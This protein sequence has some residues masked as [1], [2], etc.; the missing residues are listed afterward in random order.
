MN[1]LHTYPT[2]K[3]EMARQIFR[4]L[5]ALQLRL[6]IVQKLEILDQAEVDKCV[7]VIDRLMETLLANYELNQFD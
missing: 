2:E 7:E 3:R 1:T 4:E 5:F 6:E